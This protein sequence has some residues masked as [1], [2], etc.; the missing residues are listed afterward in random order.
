MTWDVRAEVMGRPSA[1]SG[2]P[3]G[4]SI[5]LWHRCCLPGRSSSDRGISLISPLHG[6]FLV[7]PA[8]AWVGLACLTF[9]RDIVTRQLKCSQP[10][11][12]APSLLTSHLSLLS[13]PY[14]N[15]MS[16]SPVAGS[17]KNVSA[18]CCSAAIVD[19]TREL[20]N[21]KEHDCT[22]FLTHQ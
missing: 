22:R 21:G 15:R 17:A 9:L 8:C 6:C 10:S 13:T 20:C 5:F 2:L 4:H 11:K 3:L 14:H 19:R 12:A 7:P 1:D 16:P 18:I